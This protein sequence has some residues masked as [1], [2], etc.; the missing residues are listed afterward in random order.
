MC[1]RLGGLDLPAEVP[2]RSKAIRNS[3]YALFRFLVY[4]SSQSRRRNLC[5]L[6]SW[7][8]GAWLGLVGRCELLIKSPQCGKQRPTTYV[9]IQM[10]QNPK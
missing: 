5:C 8:L 7:L 3:S 4:A 2:P 1:P 10:S 6:C 9:Q